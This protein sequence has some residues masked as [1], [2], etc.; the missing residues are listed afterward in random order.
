MYSRLHV[1]AFLKVLVVF[2]INVNI[3]LLFNIPT[4][5]L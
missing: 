1:N 5:K 4:L 3:Q 2:I